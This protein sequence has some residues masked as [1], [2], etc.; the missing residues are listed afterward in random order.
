MMGN[1]RKAHQN[2]LKQSNKADLSTSEMT[3][4][5]IELSLWENKGLNG[6]P[7]KIMNLSLIR[8]VILPIIPMDVIYN[9]KLE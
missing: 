4:I 9:S 2:T 8:V 7:V 1:T 3:K 6:H 5:F